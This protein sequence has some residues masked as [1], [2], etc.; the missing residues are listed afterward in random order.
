[1]P[2]ENHPQSQPAQTV[3]WLDLDSGA[4]LFHWL[5]KPVV[6]TGLAVILSGPIGPEYMH[7]H[8][9]MKRLAEEL[10]RRNITVF[11]FDLPGY[12][13]SSG[14][15]FDPGLVDQWKNAIEAAAAMLK[16]HSG[17]SRLGLVALRSGSLLTT[18][19]LSSGTLV[20]SLV[21]WYPYTRGSAFLRDMGMIDQ[22]IVASQDSL[23]NYIN[24][25]GY[26]ITGQSSSEI[27]PIN[28]GSIDHRVD[29]ALI[30]R[31]SESGSKSRLYR[32]LSAGGIACEEI[33]S[34]A[35]PRMA[36]QAELSEL[37][38]D[39]IAAITDWLA[40]RVGNAAASPAREYPTNPG[41]DGGYFRESVIFADSAPR[42]FGIRCEPAANRD[43]VR[44]PLVV[45][46]NSGAGHH[47]GP[48]RLGVDLARQLARAGFR[49][50]R[51]DLSNL[52]DSPV[53]KAREDNHPYPAHAV[54]D[55]DRMLQQVASDDENPCFVI[56][57]LCSGAYSAFHAQKALTRHDIVETILINPLTFY[58]QPGESIIEP[59]ASK[60]AIKQ[61]YYKSRARD[62]RIWLRLLLN[63]RKILS[64]SGFV[65]R[66]L[67]DKAGSLLRRAGMAAGLLQPPLL[68][69][70]MQSIL[71]QNR[72]ICFA[73][74]ENDP[75]YEMIMQHAG[76]LIR[77]NLESGDIT[78]K[79]LPGV[80]HTFSTL[81]SRNGLIDFI[82]GHMQ[83]RYRGE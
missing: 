51:F 47:V 83:N 76:S 43:A 39:D 24:A 48:N 66:Y 68:H 49:S 54:E 57:G 13:N 64:V 58:I 59:E 10:C 28:T 3:G 25:G 74:S 12:G 27:E 40:A 77:A 63:P 26:P 44:R 80:D 73:I 1:M 52:G 70:D 55:I 20:D 33:A 75:G 22:L 30:L 81:D 35:L 67:A 65:M 72:K 5:H 62:W 36:K 8:R 71:Q 79:R 34:A 6:N 46:T 2:G 9:A 61:S 7:C 41:F 37:P 32:Q 23:T 78:I 17:A 11:R 45:I 42:L 82:C 31:A 56:T 14:S 50:L 21:Y 29:D 18:G 15:M 69:R 60:T 53:D 38:H 19:L 16:S 4:R